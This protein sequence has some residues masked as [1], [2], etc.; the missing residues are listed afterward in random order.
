[1]TPEERAS[2]AISLSQVEIDTGGAALEIAIIA[3][4]RDAVAAEREACARRAEDQRIWLHG[5]S[6]AEQQRMQ[7]SIAD[8]IRKRGKQ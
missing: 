8:G 4:I 1:M 5:D 6:Y 7:Q 2:H 3:A